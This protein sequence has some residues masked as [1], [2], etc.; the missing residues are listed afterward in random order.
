MRFALAIPLFLTLVAP[1]AGQDATVPV[2]SQPLPPAAATIP[3]AVAPI[4]SVWGLTD[5]HRRL[6]ERVAR[7][8]VFAQAPPDPAAEEPPFGLTNVTVYRG[9]N[10]ATTYSVP[11]SSAR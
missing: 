3:P 8:P 4:P 6:L 5:A 11:R 9:P 10:E 2:P 1:A 7:E